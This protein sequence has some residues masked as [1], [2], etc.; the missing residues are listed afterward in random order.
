MPDSNEPEPLLTSAERQLLE[1]MW[2]RQAHAPRTATLAELEERAK[3]TLGGLALGLAFESLT[4]RGCIEVAGDSG[5]LRLRGDGVAL[6]QR[7]SREERS[8]FFGRWM[9]GSEQSDAYKE[10]CRRVYGFPL[11]QF[12]A[13]DQ[14]DHERLLDILC[15]GPSSR[16]VDLGCGIG[17][18]AEYISDR[19]GARVTGVDFSEVAI[20]RATER[21][22]EKSNR[23]AFQQKDLNE[24]DLPTHSFDA[25]IAFDTLYF[26]RDLQKLTECVRLSLASRGKFAVFDS[27]FRRD[28]A[29]SDCLESHGS[30]FG[31][32]LRKVGWRFSAQDLTAH[33]LRIWTAARA[34]AQELRGSF[35]AEGNLDLWE[36]RM[37]ETERILADHEAGRVRRYLYLTEAV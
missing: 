3:E 37:R 5:R 27:T 8:A 28:D 33:D 36:S 2:D 15:L 21:T 35:E 14:K 9:T 16:V 26:V 10:F 18:V 30:R 1:L 13:V 25:A 22:R 29:S 17:T 24:L 19:T 34:A 11:I 12:N 31:S 7:I 32:A 20:R 23:L 6:A 4:T